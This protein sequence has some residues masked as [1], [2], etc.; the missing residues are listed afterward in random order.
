MSSVGWGG[1]VT[2]TSV[3]SP[4]ATD[5]NRVR[6]AENARDVAWPTPASASSIWSSVTV[7][8]G[9]FE[10]ARRIENPYRARSAPTDAAADTHFSKDGV[11]LDPTAGSR[12][13]RKITSNSRVSRGRSSARTRPTRTQSIDTEPPSKP[14]TG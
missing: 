3:V 7:V 6:P 8:G 9:M 4:A 13:S 12:G 1:A 2:T 5:R 14:S 11:W 10:V